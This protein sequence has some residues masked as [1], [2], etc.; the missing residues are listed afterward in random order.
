[1]VSINTM[2]N[3]SLRQFQVLFNMSM[4]D[5]RQEPGEGEQR[6]QETSERVLEIIDAL[7][8]IVYQ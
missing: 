2:Y 1:M 4:T 7:K 5:S 8:K 6:E 3:T